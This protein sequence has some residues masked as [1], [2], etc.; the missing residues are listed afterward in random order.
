MGKISVVGIGPGPRGFMTPEA[1][2]AIQEAE[3]LIGGREALRRYPCDE[4]KVVKGDIPEVIRFMKEKKDRRVAVLTS[5]DPCFYSLLGAILREFPKEKVEIVP[6]ISSLQLCFAKIKE[7][8]NDATLVSLHGR[9][10]EELDK[11][12]DAE[13]LV[14]LTDS[15]TPPNAAAEYLLRRI[16]G[17]RR[18]FVC[19]NL[20]REG[21]KVTEGSLQD[22]AQGRF[23]GNSVMVVMS[24]K[25][26]SPR[27]VPGLPDY[28]F[29]REKAPMTKEEVRA[30]TLSKA[31]LRI[32][33]LIYDIGAGTGSISVE[34]GMLARRGRVYAVEK[35][36]LRR[37]VL[38]K[39]ISRFRAGNVEVVIGE[40]PEAIE[41]LPL[42]DRIIIG[43]SG[44]RLREILRKCDEK[45]VEDGRIVINLIALD[46]LAETVK[47]LKAL[48]YEYEATQVT[49]SKGE[50]LG[51]KVALRPRSAVFIIT[52]WRLKK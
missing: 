33:S 49:V 35:D 21:E 9:A 7:T 44:G 37:K 43:G 17:E 27:V 34:A 52:A 32:D 25:E 12:I 14:I 16:S 23:S 48:G 3:V 15:Q 2:K 26:E 10:M 29:H 24:E 30:I 22:I 8:L 45:L 1:E 42:A 31:D 18:V 36:P 50:K 5:G 28:M 46:S 40:A 20:T 47:E 19:E 38:E 41:E 51:G 4:K 39:N 13:K 11:A 6:G